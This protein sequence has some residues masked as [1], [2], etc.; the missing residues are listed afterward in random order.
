MMG[1]DEG[2]CSGS[3][4][5]EGDVGVV[6]SAVVAVFAVNYDVFESL[7]A[8]SLAEVSDFDLDFLILML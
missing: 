8:A 3:L 4:S 2:I 1:V 7:S 6:H 5:T